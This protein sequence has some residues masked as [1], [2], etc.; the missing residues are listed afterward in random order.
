MAAERG[1]DVA[2]FSALAE[3]DAQ[4]DIDLDVRLAARAREGDVVL[5]SRLAGW[6]AV[7]EGLAATKVWIAAREH[8]RA[9]R[10]GEREGVAHAE[11]MAANRDRALSESTRYRMYY[12]ID[13]G[14]LSIYDLVIDSSS[15]SPEDLAKSILAAL[16]Q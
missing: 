2:E 3:H 7:N 8:E 5:E 6:I 12:G 15:T 10:V 9:R 16:S 11:A 4:I 14:D 1:M 13:L